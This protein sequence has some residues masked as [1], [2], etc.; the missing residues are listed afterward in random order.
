MVCSAVTYTRYMLLLPSTCP[1]TQTSGSV[2]HSFSSGSHPQSR[3]P[4]TL[5]VLF[6]LPFPF[7]CFLLYNFL[8]SSVHLASLPG[9]Q[10]WPPCWPMRLPFYLCL[11]PPPPTQAESLPPMATGMLL[12]V[13]WELLGL[14]FS[15]IP[16][17][18]PDVEVIRIIYFQSKV[19]RTLLMLNYYNKR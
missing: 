5:Y 9:A 4:S 10:F 13:T 11:E 14:T 17:C 18:I 8:L 1:R 7:A 2:V 3:S 6:S 19:N 12:L 15:L 16:G